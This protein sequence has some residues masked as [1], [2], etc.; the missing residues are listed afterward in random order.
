M[1]SDELLDRDELGFSEWAKTPTPDHLVPDE[2]ERQQTRDEFYGKL[3]SDPEAICITHGD[4]DGLGAA[5]LVTHAVKG[6]VETLAVSYHGSYTLLDAL[7]DV[8][9]HPNKPSVYVTD[10]GCDDDDVLEPLEE[11]GDR[12]IWF[13]HHQWDPEI[14][15]SVRATGTELV[16]DE[17]ECGTTIAIQETGKRVWSERLSELA[18][19]TKDHDLWIKEDPRS[20][21]LGV[22]S[23]VL[24]DEHYIDVVLD[25]GVDV[26]PV[27]DEK[28]DEQLETNERLE[29]FAVTNHL[30]H[31]IG[32]YKVAFT[33]VRGGR[34]SEIG[35]RLVEEHEPSRDIAIV[36]RPAGI[37]VYSHSD[38]ET[39]NRCNEIAGELGG[40]GH[41]TASGFPIPTE[42]FR[43]QARYWSTAGKSVRGHIHKAVARVVN[44]E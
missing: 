19:V 23:Y 11:I 25:H 27:I 21:R 28:I 30:T 32:D 6:E 18:E 5:A 44:D 38:G 24:D 8:A 36:Q 40:G 2:I 41:P 34:S 37:S 4:A 17:D 10:L 22:M 43:E 31:T 16:V 13:D 1:V 7:E 39:F 15:D 26:P 20:D 14:E 42:T 3:D 35:N 29:D 33:Y 12:T 9:A